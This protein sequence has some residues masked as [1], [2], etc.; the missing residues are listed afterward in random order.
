MA[1]CIGFSFSKASVVTG[2]CNLRTGAGT[3]VALATI[4]TRKYTDPETERTS[5]RTSSHFLDDFQFRF[6]LLKVSNADF[7]ISRDPR[8]RH[9]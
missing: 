6:S 7:G 4:G 3:S 9:I 1:N 2:T 8:K 5:P